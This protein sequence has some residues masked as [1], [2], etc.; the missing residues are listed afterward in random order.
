[1]RS[2][3]PSPKEQMLKQVPLFSACSDKELSR[4]AA[5][6]DETDR[7][8]GAVLVREGQAGNEA[9]VITSGQ[10]KATLNG[11]ELATLGPGDAVG[12][13]SLLDNAPRSATV[14]AESDVHLLVLTHQTFDQLVSETPVA[15]ALLR[16]LAQRLRHTEGAPE[17]W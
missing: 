10:A 1:M 3:S 15:K 8:A 7:P 2:K 12:E 13:M 6:V 17:T 5:L 4:I 11:R 14:T 16:S 9:F